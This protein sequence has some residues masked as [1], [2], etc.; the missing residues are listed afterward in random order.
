[1]AAK[2]PKYVRNAFVAINVRL[3]VKYGFIFNLQ[4]VNDNS[5]QQQKVDRR[6]F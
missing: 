1:M 2:G 6:I 5:T 4:D 3:Q